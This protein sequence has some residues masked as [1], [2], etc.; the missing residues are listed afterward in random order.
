MGGFVVI[1]ISVLGIRELVL[2]NTV[3][4]ISSSA[5]RLWRGESGGVTKW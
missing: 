2:Q 1:V 5:D 3:F 4:L